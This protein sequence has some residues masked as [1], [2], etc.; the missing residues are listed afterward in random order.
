MRKGPSGRRRQSR[1]VRRFNL[2]NH[3]HNSEANQVDR[4]LTLCHIMTNK[5]VVGVVMAG[6]WNVSRD[7]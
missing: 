1:A 6:L 5:A 7:G 2:E 3:G 4:Q